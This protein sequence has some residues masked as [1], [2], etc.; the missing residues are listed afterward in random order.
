MAGL[1]FR[2]IKSAILFAYGLFT[3]FAYAFIQIRNGNF[4]RKSSEKEKLELYLA[5]ERF[6]NLSND[7]AGLSHQFLTL[8]NGFKFHLVCNDRPN[9]GPNTKPLVI[10]IHGFPDSWAIWRHIIRSSAIQSAATVVAIDLPGYGGSDSLGKYSATNVLEKL[11]EFVVTIR[12]LY[13]IDGDGEAE[14]RRVVIV[15]HD[16]GCVLAMR[17]AAEAPQLADRFILTNG[18]LPG[19]VISNVRRLVSSSVKMFKTALRSPLSSRSI[20]FKAMKSMKPVLRQLTRSGY[21]AAMQ[22]PMTFV[23]YLGSG[24]NYSFLR[25]THRISY[26]RTEFTIVDAAECMASSLGPSAEECKT[27][28]KDNEQYPASVKKERVFGNFDHMA[29][30]YRHGAATSRW[31]K[32]IE[33]I[34]SL[35]SIARG[36]EFRRSSSG[37]GLFDDGPEGVLKGNSTV[38]W[39]K[40]DI[41]LEPPLCLDGISDYLVH[42]SQVILLPRSGHFTPMERE[43]RVAL[44]K[45]VEWAVKG[46][47]EDIG[48]V[49]QACYPKA[50]VTIRK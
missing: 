40:E 3:M 1:L 30:Y 46:E 43:S 25:A 23:R 14:Q 28:T 50:T 26:G 42:N 13:G 20:L 41:A 33:T 48:A 36:N 47:R 5:R 10:F 12:A 29:G 37:A 39:G 17:L 32:S 38:I 34:A 19:L 24:G 18:P 11:T 49:I 15:G 45:A 2:A 4:F 21:I 8:R 31:R 6:W 44:E 16:W 9:S 7:W 35:H 27:R 22:L